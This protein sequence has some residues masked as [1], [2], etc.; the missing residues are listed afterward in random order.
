MAKTNKAYRIKG[1]QSVVACT[2]GEVAALAVPAVPAPTEGEH[3][4]LV[5]RVPLDAVQDHFRV[6]ALRQHVHCRTDV[7]RG[8]PEANL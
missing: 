5:H 1:K 3:A 8:R 2:E 6:R 7:V 4:A